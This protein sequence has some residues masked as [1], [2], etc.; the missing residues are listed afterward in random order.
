[1]LINQ[2][3]QTNHQFNQHMITLHGYTLHSIIATRRLQEHTIIRPR[4]FQ[5][6]ENSA[7]FC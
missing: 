7:G 2:F 6:Q 3:A 1:M 4:A 5:P